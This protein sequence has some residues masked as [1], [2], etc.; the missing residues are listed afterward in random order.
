MDIHKT[1]RE[2]ADQNKIWDSHGGEHWD[3]GVLD[4][5]PIVWYTGTGLREK[6]DALKI[7]DGFSAT[8]ETTQKIAR[9]HIPD[10]PNLASVSSEYQLDGR[11]LWTW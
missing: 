3:Y 11:L 1:W 5:T 10:D 2:C 6:P 4:V 7:R 8:L 9:P